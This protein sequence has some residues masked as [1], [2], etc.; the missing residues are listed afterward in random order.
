[1][2]DHQCLQ[3]LSSNP[4]NSCVLETLGVP[5]VVVYDHIVDGRS[6]QL[7][8]QTQMFPVGALVDEVVEKLDYMMGRCMSPT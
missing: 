1:M 4:E 8:Y 3:E 5:P 7:K 2:H 6:K